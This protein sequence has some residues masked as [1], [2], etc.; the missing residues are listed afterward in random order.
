MKHG[1][2]LVAWVI[3]LGVIGS[4]CWSSK[5]TLLYQ[6]EELETI[7]QDAKFTIYGNFGPVFSDSLN[8]DTVMSMLKDK[9]PQYYEMLNRYHVEFV[10][11]KSDYLIALWKDG[12]L[13]I[14]DYSCTP[15]VDGKMYLGPQKAIMTDLVNG[16]PCA[17]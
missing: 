14:Y 4:G 5:E 2:L 9:E 8:A 17:K 6:Y 11:M 10:F 7:V 3:L 12:C 15:K 16:S 1:N 13:V